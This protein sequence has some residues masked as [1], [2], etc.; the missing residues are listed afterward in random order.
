MKKISFILLSAVV[1]FGT[2]CMKDKGFEDQTY[3]INDPATSKDG[4]G[5]NLEG[6]VNYKKNV[7]LVVSDQPQVIDANKLMIGFYSEAPAKSDIKVQIALDPSIIDDYNTNNGTS[8]VEMDPASYTVASTTITIPAGQQ[9]AAV[10]VTVPSTT[11]FDPNNSYGLAF[12]IVS[13]DGDAQIAANMNKVMLEINIKNIYDGDYVSNGYFYHPTAPRPMIDLAKTF[14]T[15][16]A[17]S[18]AVALGDLGPS[19]Y[20]SIFDVDPVT[21]ALTITAYPNG[22]PPL[23]MW[24]SG[25][26]TTGPGYTPQWAR[27]AECNN[28]YDAATETFQV[29]YGYVGATGWRVTEEIIVKE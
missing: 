13:V 6:S 23:T 7:G 25:L 5:F 12:K 24:T 22:T 16:N 28:T 3:G 4:V 21:N 2:S 1:L 18:C 9:R 19:G 27:S 14:F 17:T 8:I 20:Y 15:L 11:S 29:R 10:V 26:P